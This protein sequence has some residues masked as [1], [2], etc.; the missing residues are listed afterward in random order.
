[1]L[2]RKATQSSD[3]QKV[4]K[5]KAKQS[6]FHSSLRTVNKQ[7]LVEKPHKQVNLQHTATLFITSQNQLQV[8]KAFHN[9]LVMQFQ[10]AFFLLATLFYVPE[11]LTKLTDI[12]CLNL[13]I[14]LLMYP[15]FLP[16]LLFAPAKPSRFPRGGRLVS[17]HAL[18]DNSSPDYQKESLAIS[19][20]H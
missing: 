5:I 16:R 2:H 12:G 15:V 9:A 10:S 18:E 20:F 3:Q 14:I 1:M 8:F 7:R 19:K 13:V 6:K 11:T 17:T 4:H